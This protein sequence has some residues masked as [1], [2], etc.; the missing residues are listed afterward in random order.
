MYSMY[1]CSAGGGRAL[2]ERGVARALFPEAP[3][4]E[5]EHDERQRRSRGLGEEREP[6]LAH[7][8]RDVVLA[9]EAEE[10]E[11]EAGDGDAAHERDVRKVGRRRVFVE[12][13]EARDVDDDGAGFQRRGGE[14]V[15]GRGHA[16]DDH[17]APGDGR[18]R[19][20]HRRRRH[21][22]LHD[23]DAA[24]VDGVDRRAVVGQH[25]AKRPA[26]DL[27]AVHDGDDD[28]R[29]RV[30]RADELLFVH[31]HVLQA[32][33]HGERRA[34]QN[35]L[36]RA[37]LVEVADVGVE[38]CAVLVAEALDVLFRRDAVAELVVHAPAEERR[39]GAEDGV[40]DEDA[41]DA[42]VDVGR[43]HRRL[44]GQRV[45]LAQ[46]VLD[47]IGGGGAARPLCVL[48]RRRVVVGQE[49]D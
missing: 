41:V 42:V 32:L 19:V 39:P 26:H 18:V 12:V 31:A 20:Q 45:A 27:A 22:A 38:V 35:G 11:L 23:V 8:P 5:E 7:D 40:V 2:S 21:A 43:V 28:A 46:L 44:E 15:V 10:R 1:S 49:A 6:A 36:G 24:H 17:V 47:A 9:V 3:R 29:E 30:R 48:A 25:G 14:L 33:D 4:Q 13:L 34:R 37:P 16:E